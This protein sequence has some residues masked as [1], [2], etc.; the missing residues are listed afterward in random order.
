MQNP[1]ININF[2]V[3]TN[4][5]H[6]ENEFMFMLLVTKMKLCYFYI[7]PNENLLRISAFLDGEERN[8]K[9]SL[10]IITVLTSIYEYINT[11]S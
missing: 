10:V 7:L 8:M 1:N 11:S 2:H 4:S 5:G 6:A 3:T 9:Q